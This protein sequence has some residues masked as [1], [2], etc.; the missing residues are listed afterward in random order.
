MRFSSLQYLYLLALRMHRNRNAVLISHTLWNPVNRNSWSGR[1]NTPFSL[2]KSS[3]RDDCSERVET[4]FLSRH[5][6]RSLLLEVTSLSKD[7]RNS[8]Q[9]GR[10]MNYFLSLSLLTAALAQHKRQHLWLLRAWEHSLLPKNF[11][12]LQALELLCFVM[13]CPVMFRYVLWELTE[14]I[15]IFTLKMIWY[16]KRWEESWW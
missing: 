5:A 13:F 14:M 15:K 8:Y 9:W 16:E 4:T 1:A 11:L 2:I 10:H 6:E 3:W 12:H 7:C